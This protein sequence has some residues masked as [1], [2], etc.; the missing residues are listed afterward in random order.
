MLS[1]LPQRCQNIYERPLLPHS[2]VGRVIENNK[3]YS[4]AEAYASCSMPV[5]PVM[6]HPEEEVKQEVMSKQM[7]STYEFAL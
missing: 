7:H 5:S 6:V 1:T 3:L 4:L 2:L